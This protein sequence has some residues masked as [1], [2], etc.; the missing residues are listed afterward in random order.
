MF[1]NVNNKNVLLI[2]RLVPKFL[3]LTAVLEL[4]EDVVLV[5][6]STEDMDELLFVVATAV[7]LLI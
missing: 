7:V 2:F 3:E 4:E 6:R 1:M 5:D